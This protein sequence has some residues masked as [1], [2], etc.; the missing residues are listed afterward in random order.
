M[1]CNNLNLKFIKKYRG[2]RIAKAILKRE[3]K[4]CFQM[5]KPIMKL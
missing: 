3:G 4:I 5:L 2:P 1:E